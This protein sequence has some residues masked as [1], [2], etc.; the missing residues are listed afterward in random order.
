MP[1]RSQSLFHELLR[2]TRGCRRQHAVESCPV[3]VFFL[4]PLQYPLS[5]IVNES[6]VRHAL[7]RA[8]QQTHSVHLRS[9]VLTSRHHHTPF[10]CV[11]QLEEIILSLQSRLIYREMHVSAESREQ[12]RCLNNQDAPPPNGKLGITSVDLPQHKRVRIGKT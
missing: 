7:A 2:T 4:A 6:S 8:E 9:L 3:L 5:S 10:H 11:L 1:F 12:R